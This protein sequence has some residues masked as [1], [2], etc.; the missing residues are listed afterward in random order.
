MPLEL[1]LFLS[2]KVAN[3]KNIRIDG[4]CCV[5]T[6]HVSLLKNKHYINIEYMW[7]VQPGYHYA[8]TE[9]KSAFV[10]IKDCY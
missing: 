2:I 8:Y 5:E 7:Y 6:R 3:Y 10:S 9:N 1:T 4:L